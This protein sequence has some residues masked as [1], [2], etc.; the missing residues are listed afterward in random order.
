M[1][2]QAEA[3]NE[4][5]EELTEARKSIDGQ[6][7]EVRTSRGY[8]LSAPPWGDGHP[9]SVAASEQKVRGFIGEVTGKPPDDDLVGLSLDALLESAEALLGERRTQDQSSLNRETAELARRRGR[10][11]N[12]RDIQ[13]QVSTQK[14]NIKSTQ[15]KL[16]TVLDGLTSDELQEKLEATKYKATTES[17]KRRIVQNA[18]VLIGRDESETVPCPICDSHHDR[19]ILESALQNTVGH[20]DNELSSIVDGLESQLQKSEELQNSLNVQE[21][22]LDLLKQS[23]TS[24]MSLVVDDD[25]RKLAETNDIDQLIKNYS[26]KESMVKAQIDDQETWFMSKRA[27]LDRLKVID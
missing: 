14:S 25:K 24:T 10:L 12:L 4:L 7:L 5:D 13:S 16:D 6:I 2:A 3:E 15:A 23:A 20:P 11:E 19:Q 18:I 9:P 8:I 1:E 17:I 21:T 26:E 22:V 27:Q